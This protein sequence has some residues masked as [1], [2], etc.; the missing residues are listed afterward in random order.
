MTPVAW[1]ERQQKGVVRAFQLDVAG[2]KKQMLLFPGWDLPS[3]SGAHC[4]HAALSNKLIDR[5][6]RLLCVEREKAYVGPIVEHIEFLGLTSRTR[7]HAADLHY[8]VLEP[9]ERFDFA[10][11]DFLGGYGG[12][13]AQ[14]IA[15]VFTPQILDG[16]DISLTV[17]YN[18]RANNFF[19]ECEHAFETAFRDEAAWAKTALKIEDPQHLV[20]ALMLIT[21]FRDFQFRYHAP[22]LYQD[23]VTPMLGFKLT[24]LTRASKP[25]PWPSI[26]DVASAGRSLRYQPVSRREFDF[27][28]ETVKRRMLRQV[29]H[30]IEGL[31]VPG[32]LGDHPEAG[33]L[34]ASTDAIKRILAE[35]RDPIKRPGKPVGRLN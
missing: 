30:N 24:G 4:I 18:E 28:A 13:T 26:H 11:L 9:H 17:S 25:M 5:R 22:Y 8:L 3:K 6:T 31:L 2:P 12:K 16:A 10:Y 1:G 29:Q 19:S 32:M 23:S 20:H 35:P 7:M 21:L 14:W 33:A 27:E 34:A 15:D